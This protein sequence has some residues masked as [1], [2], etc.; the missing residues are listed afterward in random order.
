VHTE[1]HF[2]SINEIFVS[3]AELTKKKLVRD[4][5]YRQLLNINTFNVEDEKETSKRFQKYMK[6]KQ[7]LI[8]GN[9]ENGRNIFHIAC[10]HR[11]TKY[12]EELL[13]SEDSLKTLLCE[14]DEFQWT[15][16]HYACRFHPKNEKLIVELLEKCPDAVLE[17]D[18]CNRHPLHIACN[19]MASLKVIELLLRTEENMETERERKPSVLTR[20][21]YLKV[22]HSS[23]KQPH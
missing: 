5:C 21:K 1:G 3:L 8:N 14:K 17:S 9:W 19:S 20:T 15:P 6:R 11:D 4:N 23:I 13:D 12:I 22:R 7:P 18:R 16:L 10:R 2:G